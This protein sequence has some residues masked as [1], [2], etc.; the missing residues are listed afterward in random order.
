M[1]VSAIP[2]HAEPRL[3]GPID[4]GRTIGSG[5]VRRKP[6]RWA[7][8]TAALLL[9]AGI[10][11]AVVGLRGAMVREAPALPAAVVVMPSAPTD[12]VL[13]MAIPLGAAADQQAGGPGYQ[14]PAVV[15][16]TVGDTI[17]IRNDDDAPHMFL[18]A[19]LKPG[20]THERTLTAPGSET[21]SAG[22]GVH[23]ASY[24]TFT[25]IF[26]REPARGDAA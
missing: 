3:S 15:S 1:I 21:Y 22:C 20:E 17:V 14:M 26:V 2:I 24:N 12:G 8:V 5:A 9:L 10:A 16:L 18:Y 25:T 4:D 13:A 6:R 23:A 19:F 7:I 11:L